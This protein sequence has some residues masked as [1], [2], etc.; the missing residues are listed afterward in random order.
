MQRRA[1]H[2]SLALSD[3]GHL[4]PSPST[5]TIV[6]R[7]PRRWRPRPVDRQRR[8]TGPREPLWGRFTAMYCERRVPIALSCS[9]QR[10]GRR[11][12]RRFP[13]PS[14]LQ[15]LEVI[16]V[17]PFK[18]R[19]PRAHGIPVQVSPL[20]RQCCDGSVRLRS[21]PC[22]VGVA[23][24]TRATEFKNPYHDCPKTSLLAGADK[25]IE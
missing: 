20:S 13:A 3:L 19:V 18:R 23:S 10:R 1:P 22:T 6:D 2:F 11:S 24:R 4:R 7:S 12:N 9:P 8:C 14:D 17:D 25:M 21:S 5:S 15:I 16:P